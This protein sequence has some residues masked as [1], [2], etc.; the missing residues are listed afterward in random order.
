MT[1]ILEVDQIIHA[2]T[3]RP[4]GYVD[5]IMA[6]GV[7][8]HAAKTVELTREQYNELRAKYSGRAAVCCGE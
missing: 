6:V 5:E 1:I 7:V 4:P 8:D 3:E 2:A